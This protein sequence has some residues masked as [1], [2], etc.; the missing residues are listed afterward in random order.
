MP[1]VGLPGQYVVDTTP[2][3]EA[4]PERGPRIV[5]IQNK[6]VEAILR[7]PFQCLLPFTVLVIEDRRAI[8]RRQRAAYMRVVVQT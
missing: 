2:H 3:G 7:N 1:A 4:M 6:Q 5:T 8:P